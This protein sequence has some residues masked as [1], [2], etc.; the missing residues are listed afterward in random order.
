[1][2]FV[3]AHAR[4]PGPAGGGPPYW[5]FVTVGQLGLSVD[6]VD[7]L[8]QGQPWDV[9]HAVVVGPGVNLHVSIILLISFPHWVRYDFCYRDFC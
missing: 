4:T 9:L 6:L 2:W 7:L 8:A 1:M 5:T 3:T